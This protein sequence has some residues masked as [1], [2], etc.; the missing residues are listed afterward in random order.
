MSNTPQIVQRGDS[1]NLQFDTNSFPGLPSSSNS[2]NNT[3][4]NNNFSLNRDEDFP[5]LSVALDTK[6]VES[7]SNNNS[8]SSNQQDSIGSGAGGFVNSRA[9]MN[10]NNEQTSA[11]GVQS[12]SNDAAK[13]GLTGLLDV[14]RITDRVSTYILAIL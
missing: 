2:S 8:N 1:A 13:Y 10:S 14:L 5:A 12:I 7:S 3:R 11:G 6:V 9:G 4:Y